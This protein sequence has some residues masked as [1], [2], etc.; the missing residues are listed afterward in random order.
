MARASASAR[1][2]GIV[3]APKNDASVLSLQSGT[4]PS[5]STCL[6]TVTVSSTVKSGQRS[7]QSPQAELRKPRSKGALW[8]VS[9]RP[10]AKLSKAGS[11]SPGCGAAATI[12]L[13]I[14]VRAS[15]SPGTGTPGLTS[16]VNSPSTRPARIRTAPIS[17][18]L[19]SAGDQPV[20][21]TSTTA[22]STCVSAIPA[23][24]AATPRGPAG[25]R[26][27]GVQAGAVGCRSVTVFTVGHPADNSPPG[28]GPGKRRV[29]ERVAGMSVRAGMSVAAPNVS[30]VHS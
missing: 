3:D 28:A 17:V 6:A 24:G 11:A 14:P 22:N 4:S 25:A 26:A 19:A 29:P 23:Q 18:I 7:P 21:S 2:H 1:W 15:M 12:W 30:R 9:T 10:P 5:P 16:V 20:V 27:P 8:A 13:V